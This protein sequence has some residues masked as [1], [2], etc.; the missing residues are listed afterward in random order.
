M[1]DR[2]EISTTLPAKVEAVYRGWLDPVEHAAFVGGAAAIAPGVGGAYDI[3]DGY[4]TGRTLE[5][6]PP[7]RIVQSW[8]T[9]EF[10]EGSPDSHLEVR[11]EPDGSA[12][13]L[14]LVHSEIPDGQGPQYEEGWKE[15]YFTPMK[16]YFSE[17]HRPRAD[18]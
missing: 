15:H 11:L 7:R 6:D 9:T 14:T 12:T 4:I 3:W 1:S 2:F 13:R 17:T 16:A 10:P 5:L 18:R 8:R